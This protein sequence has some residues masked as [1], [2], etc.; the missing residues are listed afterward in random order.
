MI[1]LACVA[2]LNPKP[3][4]AQLDTVLSAFTKGSVITVDN[5]VSVLSALCKS[6]VAYEA[7][8]MLLLL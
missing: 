3:I 2:E 1:A 6:D 4:F 8:I 7:R 5:A